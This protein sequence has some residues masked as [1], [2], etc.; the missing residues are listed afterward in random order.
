MNMKRYDLY[1]GVFWLLFGLFVSG[2]SLLDL[3]L[4]SFSHPDPGLFPFLIGVIMSLVALISIIVAIAAGR[5]DPTF[6]KWPSFSMKIP[7]TIGVLC[8]YSLVL[9][10]LGYLISTSILLIYIF[11]FP[12]SRNW[13]M[14]FLMTVAV[15]AVS[16]YFFVVLLKSQLPGGILESVIQ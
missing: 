13:R 3:G 2:A 12:A 6:G 7:I 9:E 14:S 11:K 4:G 1:C 16:Y 5:K 15:M 8:L 10:C